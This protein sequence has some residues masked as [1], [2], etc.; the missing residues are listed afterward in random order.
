MITRA[1]VKNYKNHAH[2]EIPLSRVTLLGGRNNV[3]K[4]NLLEAL[5]LHHD[6]KNP[7]FII[8]QYAFRGLEQLYTIPETAWAPIF[9]DYDIGKKCSIS[10]TRD[11][12]EEVLEIQFNPSFSTT[13]PINR[14]VTV[15]QT[16]I[17]SSQA[18]K[19]I[20]ALDITF[21][22]QGKKVQDNH[23]VLDHMGYGVVFDLME[24][25]ITA[26]AVF[27]A[28]R[29]RSNQNEDAMR[30]GVLD[31]DNKTESITE[32]L[33]AI[34]PKLKNLS[35]V[36]TG[37][38][39]VMYA[40]IS[41]NKQ[42]MPVA[43]LGDGVS[44]LLSII[45]AIANSKN[46]IVFIDEIENGIHYSVM[47]KVWEGIAQAADRFNCQIVATTHSYECLKAAYEGFSA[48]REDFSYI[49]LDLSQSKNN[50]NTIVNTIVPRKF[51]Y[52]SLGEAL[53]ND[54]EVR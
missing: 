19:T 46:G 9:R 34:E 41:G 40:D 52:E 12:R 15:E 11:G 8:R 1:V 37:L 25:N 4:T 26:P 36:S 21:K 49:R 50:N 24:S 54:W 29:A 6:R 42:K 30:F 44:R 53:S 18:L 20:T 16:N 17:A 5:F 33:R 27:M 13:K 22:I 32:I 48:R 39:S 35:A 7:Q 45:L 43:M 3:G 31:I 47:P 38:F 23:L 2:T 10:V 51:S 28:S 14:F